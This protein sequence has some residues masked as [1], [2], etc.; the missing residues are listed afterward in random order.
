MARWWSGSHAS[1]QNLRR[2]FDSFT[3]LQFMSDS[4]QK[5]DEKFDELITKQHSTFE[6]FTES[7]RS[8][9]ESIEN[10]D[11][12]LDEMLSLQE[13]TE[14]APDPISIEQK[15]EE[16]IL[17]HEVTKLL[18]NEFRRRRENSSQEF[19]ENPFEQ[20]FKKDGSRW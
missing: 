11:A 15:Y 16:E 20:F 17:I 6:S 19:D 14:T 7:K 12:K 4:I 9:E 13:S 5:D 3:G 18:D 10:D 1:L 8:K 2:K